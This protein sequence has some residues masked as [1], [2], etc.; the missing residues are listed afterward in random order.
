MARSTKRD[1]RIFAVESRFQKMAGRPGGV[2]REMAI[3]R[4]ERVIDQLKPEFV[5]WLDRKLQELNAAIEQAEGNSYDVSW[6]ERAYRVSCEIQ[7]VGTTMGFEL[8]TFIANNLCKVLEVIKTGTAYDRDMIKC[9]IDALFLARTEPYRNLGPEQ[10][11]EMT[12]GLRRVV[13]LVSKNF[14]TV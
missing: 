8:V 3:A 1:A 13:E 14:E 12:G 11:P 2:S 10:L 5:N 6:H 4:A 7:D 9:H